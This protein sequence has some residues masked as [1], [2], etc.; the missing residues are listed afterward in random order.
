[1][2]RVYRYKSLR[3]FSL[4]DRI[5]VRAPLSRLQ[6]HFH[7]NAAFGYGSVGKHFFLT[8]LLV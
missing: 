1:M 5:V 2:N 6:F 8:W 4:R 7:F 3:K